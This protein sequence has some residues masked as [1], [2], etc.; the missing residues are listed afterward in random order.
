MSSCD[1]SARETHNLSKIGM[2]VLF[3]HPLE[4]KQSNLT[5]AP[6]A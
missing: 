1:A 5:F 6:V 4:Q 3:E 2:H